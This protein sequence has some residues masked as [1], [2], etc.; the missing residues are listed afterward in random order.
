MKTS[1]FINISRTIALLLILVEAKGQDAVVFR[2]IDYKGKQIQLN[3]GQSQLVRFDSAF[4][5]RINN[6]KVAVKVSHLNDPPIPAYFF[7]YTEKNL[8]S[9]IGTNQYYKGAYLLECM[10]VAQTYQDLPQP[11]IFVPFDYSNLNPNG[12]NDHNVPCPI[13]NHWMLM[14]RKAFLWENS[15]DIDTDDTFLGNLHGPTAD[16]KILVYPPD[17]LKYEEED[18][19]KDRHGFKPKW[20]MEIPGPVWSAWAPAGFPDPFD[21]WLDGPFGCL[22]SNIPLWDW[23][24]DPDKNE[25]I[26]VIIDEADS[27]GG[28][29]IGK[30]QFPISPNMQGL[31]LVKIWG[32]GWLLLENVKI[33]AS[34]REKSVDEGDVYWYGGWNGRYPEHPRGELGVYNPHV[35][36]CPLCFENC[37]RC[38][39][40]CFIANEAVPEESSSGKQF[41]PF[42]DQQFW[43]YHQNPRYF[44]Q[45]VGLLGGRFVAETLN[46]PHT[47]TAIDE[48]AIFE[49]APN[50]TVLQITDNSLAKVKNQGQS[51]SFSV[52]PNPSDGLLQINFATRN[53]Q[54]IYFELFD[55]LGRT[56]K[57]KRLNAIY[58][59]GSQQATLDLSGLKSGLYY[60]LMKSGEYSEVQ[61]IL[62]SK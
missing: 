17:I 37:Q 12:D 34:G 41:R 60:L 30:S 7:I 2:Q 23:G 39:N 55:P 49:A 42:T 48:P 52:F 62:V 31:I 45:T 14:L 8:P 10:P 28:P 16:V 26:A 5:I 57:L 47:Y 40:F 32:F 46:T 13:A 22:Y 29:I 51:G 38:P 27:G 25:R 1:I 56:L 50:L 33:P 35:D 58:S 11:Q 6:P 61:K 24:A 4:S 15:E 59:K 53:N 44:G 19:A 21:E 20:G 18:L 43:E 54:E 9:P 3:L 36:Y